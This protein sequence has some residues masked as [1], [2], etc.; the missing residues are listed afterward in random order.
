VYTNTGNYKNYVK[1]A[2]GAA[3]NYALKYPVPDFFL[4]NPWTT[5]V[6]AMKQPRIEIFSPWIILTW[7][8]LQKSILHIS[9]HGWSIMRHMLFQGWTVLQAVYKFYGRSLTLNWHVT[10]FD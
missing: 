5:Y 10:G 2:K 3:N 1:V 4:S 7:I 6:L 8:V 9:F